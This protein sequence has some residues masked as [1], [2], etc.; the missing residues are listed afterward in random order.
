MDRQSNL[1]NQPITPKMVPNKNTSVPA[2]TDFNDYLRATLGVIR[3]DTI[4]IQ[5][6]LSSQLMTKMNELLYIIG[7][8]DAEIKELSCQMGNI[9]KTVTEQRVEIL[10]LND[11]IKTKGTLHLRHTSQAAPPEATKG[12][13]RSSILVKKPFRFKST[14]GTLYRL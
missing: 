11:L 10:K 7:N 1:M 2:Y 4:N 14:L 6:I 3:D 5:V 12:S 9:E 13:P 8:M